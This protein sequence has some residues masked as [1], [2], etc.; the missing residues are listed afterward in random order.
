MSNY[1][2]IMQ[3]ALAARKS[4]SSGVGGFGSSFKRS[5][6]SQPMPSQLGGGGGL[7]GR[8]ASILDM[9]D[10]WQKDA[11][12]KKT[13]A[14]TEYIE[15]KTEESKQQTEFSNVEAKAQKLANVAK[16]LKNAVSFLPTV[17]QSNYNDFHSWIIESDFV[18][19]NTFKSP[20]EVNSMSPLEFN[21]YKSNLSTLGST[22]MKTLKEMQDIKDKED[23][24][25]VRVEELNAKIARAEK[26]TENR[27]KEKLAEEARKSVTA[28]RKEYPDVNDIPEDVL[29]E[30]E[31][32]TSIWNEYIGVEPEPETIEGATPAQ[33]EV[34]TALGNQQE[35]AQEQLEGY[36]RMYPDKTDEQIIAA[37][38]ASLR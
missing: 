31:R 19:A 6:S 12:L 33:T 26:K 35:L 36:R 15:A 23:K 30:Y 37:Y 4:Y 11:T 17:E 21:V 7:G 22:S 29:P 10:K 9:S 13:D 20:D 14:D 25:N 18:P 32:A 5:N 27:K 3:R 38:E 24:E 34:M 28:I 2:D 8:G 1:T 16:G